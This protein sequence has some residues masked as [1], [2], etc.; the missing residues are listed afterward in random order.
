MRKLK[1]IPPNFNHY[2]S[3]GLLGDSETIT[4][5]DLKQINKQLKMFNLEIIYFDTGAA[6]NWIIH[7]QES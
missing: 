5:S 1:Q 3:L 7:L 4:V 6:L 2:D